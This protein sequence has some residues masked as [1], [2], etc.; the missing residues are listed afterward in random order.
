M[1]CGAVANGE[2]HVTLAAISSRADWV[3]SP[4]S[5]SPS[6]DPSDLERSISL[7]ISSLSARASLAAFCSAKRLWTG[8]G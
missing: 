7:I 2:C 4:P 1:S 8:V 5:P 3:A 6:L